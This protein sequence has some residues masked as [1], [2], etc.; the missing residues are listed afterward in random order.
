MIKVPSDRLAT[1]T[2]R[3]GTVAENAAINDRGATAQG[4]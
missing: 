3:G 2:V 1:L 4:N